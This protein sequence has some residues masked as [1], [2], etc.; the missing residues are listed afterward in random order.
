MFAWLLR[1]PNPIYAAHAGRLLGHRF[2]Q[3][4]HRGRRPGQ[5]HA[6]VLEVLWWDRH[7]HEAV[8]MSGWGRKANWYRNVLASG[9]ANVTIG[10]E[11]WPARVRALG[12]AEAAAVLADY[13]HRNRF[14]RPVVRHRLGR[15]AGIDYDGSESARRTLA[16]RLPFVAFTQDRSSRSAGR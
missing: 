11:R 14:M 4:P 2:L 3:L 6:T 8:V 7:T 9:T 16:L 15:L 13:E 10:A 1:A 12:P 5:S